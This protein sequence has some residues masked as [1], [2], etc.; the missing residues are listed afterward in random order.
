MKLSA[1]LMVKNEEHCLRRCLDSVKD[2]VDEIVIVD[3]GSTDSTVE[4]AKEYTDKIYFHEWENNFSKH[5]NQSISYAT[6]DWILI[7]DADEE[8]FVHP[9]SSVEEL[10]EILGDI[11]SN[12]GC[13]VVKLLDIQNNSLIMSCNS[14]RLFKKGNIHYESIIHNEPKYEGK[15]GL[16]F[17]IYINH[18]G[19]DLPKDKMEAKFKRT[20]SLLFE[21]L[22]NEPN[23]R[24]IIFYLTQYYAQY[25]LA[26]EAIKY[27][28]QYLSY[29]EELGKD[30]NQ[31]IFYTIIKLYQ[32]KEQYDDA[33]RVIKLG[34]KMND[35]NIDVVYS[36]LDQGCILA[37]SYM[38]IDAAVK[39]VQ[40]FKF[41]M[42]NQH[43][44]EGT[45][46]F[47]FNDNHYYNALYRL[48]LSHLSEG[49]NAWKYF[50]ENRLDD[51]IKN[52]PT[53][54]DEIRENL[55]NIRMNHLLDDKKSK[56]YELP[57]L[58]VPY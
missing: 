33:L 10:K 50:K 43:L 26:E 32:D 3:T 44:S 51:V 42:E 2:V 39:Y 30:F 5:R 47:T 41:Y 31:S 7:I 46:Q 8:L 17:D 18:Y 27:G 9:N 53:L 45:F 40:L 12:Y 19:Y 13:G 48:A 23:N 29:I 55:S 20:T 52:F 6:G 49:M 24:E 16:L 57:K 36:L 15:S 28:E 22:K 37:D 14:A 54:Y 1:C 35:K 4:I 38:I 21:K 56:L 58:I 34:M 25:G 11:R